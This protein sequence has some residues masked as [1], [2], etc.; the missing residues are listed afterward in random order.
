MNGF[1]RNRAATTLDGVPEASILKSWTLHKPS[2][3][4]EYSG[5]LLIKGVLTGDR[6]GMD[7]SSDQQLPDWKPMV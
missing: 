6:G 3:L 2:L 1:S 7:W 5:T 4:Q